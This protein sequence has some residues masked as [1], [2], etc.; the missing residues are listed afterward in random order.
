VVPAPLQ[1]QPDDVFD[2]YPRK[3]QFRWDPVSISGAK[4]RLE[5]DAFGARVANKWA[6]EVNQTFAVYNNLTT[7]TFEHNFVGAQ[8]GRWRVGA[9][10]NGRKCSWP[11]WSYFRFTI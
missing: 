9:I 8:R 4:Y 2:H 5:M 11:P 6:E 3:I 1:P 10:V 7:H